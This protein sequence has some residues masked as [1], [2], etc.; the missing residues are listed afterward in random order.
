MALFIRRRGLSPVK[1]TSNP[2]PSRFS[3]WRQHLRLLPFFCLLFLC[4][5]FRVSPLFYETV[6]QALFEGTSWVQK[7]VRGPFREGESLFKGGASFL[8]LRQTLVSLQQENEA[9]KWKLQNL[10]RLACEHELL[11]RTLK[12]PDVTPYASLPVRILATPY[13]GLHRV[14]VIAGGRSQGLEKSQ[15]VISPDGVVGRIEKVGG[16]I[17][18]VLLLNDVRSRVP[19]VTRD[20][21][22]KAIL[23]GEGGRFPV[24]VYVGNTHKII[25]GEKVVT[26]GLGG[27]FPPGLPIGVVDEVMNGKVRVRLSVSLQKLDWVHVLRL[28]SSETLQERGKI[29]EG[30]Q[31]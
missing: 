17:A 14:C 25:K 2:Y 22:Q 7:I 27:V 16:D 18:R 31:F 1:P 10:D 6:Q 4:V 30:E 13:D 29:L 12:L 28:Q 23:V 21:T 5:I 26:S 15:A 8:Q 24:L 11:R 19:V 9:L 3:R 20:S